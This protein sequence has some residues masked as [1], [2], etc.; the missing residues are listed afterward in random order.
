MHG[1]LKDQQGTLLLQVP[2]LGWLYGTLDEL[3][4]HY[5]RYDRKGLQT[6]LTQAGFEVQQI[7]YFNSFGVIPWFINARILRPRT[8]S[9]RSVGLQIKV[10][11]RFIVPV[12]R[13]SEKLVRLPLGQ[14][15][16]AVAVATGV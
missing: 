14:S 9:N 4:G 10:F 8:L 13:R 6:M 3:A 2:A 1:I 11:D 5:R 15:L 7:Y 12:L 16:I